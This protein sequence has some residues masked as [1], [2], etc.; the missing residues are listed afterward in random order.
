MVHVI[1]S[2]SMKFGEKFGDPNVGDEEFAQMQD[3]LLKLKNGEELYD[4]ELE[5]DEEIDRDEQ[6]DRVSIVID[7]EDEMNKSM[8]DTSEVII[9]DQPKTEIQK[10]L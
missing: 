10:E 1:K 2:V 8:D 4:D 3:E 6:I 9:P 5:D 7:E